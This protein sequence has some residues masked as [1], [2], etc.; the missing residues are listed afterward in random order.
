M[1]KSI[2]FGAFGLYSEAADVYLRI[3][4][5]GLTVH[6]VS[7]TL[8][9]GTFL[10]ATD[11]VTLDV[12]VANDQLIDEAEEGDSVRIITPM[13]LGK[14]FS[15]DGESNEATFDGMNAHSAIE[16]NDDSRTEIL[17][18]KPGSN[19]LS[20]SSADMGTLGIALSWYLRR[21]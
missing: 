2:R 15:I 21:T 13:L 6:F 1:F 11:N 4:A 14:E 5:A 3:E 7:A 16:L 19:E 10:T 17:R 18:L 9:T 20:I 8:P 12:S